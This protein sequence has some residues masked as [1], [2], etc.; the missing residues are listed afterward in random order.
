MLVTA[1]AYAA[2]NDNFLDLIL[3]ASGGVL[4]PGWLIWATR[5]GTGSHTRTHLG[6]C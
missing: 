6:I 1:G 2:G 4:L 3:I 5:I